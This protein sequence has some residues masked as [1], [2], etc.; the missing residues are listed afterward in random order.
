MARKKN[1]TA[2]G[3]RAAERRPKSAKV[4]GFRVVY[5][6]QQ[7]QKRVREIAG[8]I[9]R[10][11]RG[12]T[13]H[14]VGVLENCFLFMADLVRALKVPTVCL[15]LKAEVRD[16]HSGEAPVRE[17]MYTP[18]VDA[19]GKDILLVDG[20]LQSGVTLDHLYRYMLGRNANSV[21]TATLIE[22]TDERKVDVP[23]DYVGFKNKGKFLLGYGMAYEGKYRNLPCVAARN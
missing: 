16:S 17:I 18:K 3:K 9:N 8:Q 7:I 12:R 21:R 13:L 23:T 20:I 11:Y 14:V 4:N 2:R 5:T 19:E 22:K 1:Q 6:R 15:F 10:D